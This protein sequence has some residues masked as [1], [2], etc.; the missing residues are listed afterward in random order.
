MSFHMVG[1]SATGV[2]NTDVDMTPVTDGLMVIQNGHF[3]PQNDMFI[4]AAGVFGLTQTSARLVS[5]TLRQ[6]TTPFIR[7]LDNAANPGNLAG[8]ARYNLNPFR[9]KGLEELS[10]VMKNTSTAVV[11]AAAAL[12]K[13][14]MLPAAQGNIFTMQG[15]GTTTLTALGWTS[16]AITWQDSLPAGVYQCVGLAALSATCIAARLT[17]ENQWERPG[18]FGASGV[19]VQEP[20]LFQKGELGVFGNFNSYRLP[21]VEF[22]AVSADTAE[23]VYLDF[24]KVG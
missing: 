16:V 4:L 24:I 18:C 21:G 14:P 7:P 9:I 23:T 12:S 20:R 3:L 1:W 17:F 6:I 10:L 19:T 2:A 5:P 11:K 15:T 8:Y 13:T 22:F